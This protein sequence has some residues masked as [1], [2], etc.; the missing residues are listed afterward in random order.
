MPEPVYDD[1]IVVAGM[2]A[3]PGSEAGGVAVGAYRGAKRV[4]GNVERTFGLRAR[5][6]HVSNLGGMAKTHEFMSD[7]AR[8]FKGTTVIPVNGSD[9]KKQA[10]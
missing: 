5:R 8:A 1:G 2:L 10:Q 4:E 6:V 7:F 9:Y 3:H